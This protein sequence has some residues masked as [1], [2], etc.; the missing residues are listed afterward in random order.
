M[1]R[2]RLYG[3]MILEFIGY[4]VFAGLIIYLISGFSFGEGQEMLLEACALYTMAGGMMIA[5]ILFFNIYQSFV[6][7]ALSL[8][9]RRK[10]VFLGLQIVK[11]LEAFGVTA[12]AALLFFLGITLGKDSGFHGGIWLAVM[13]FCLMFIMASVG[14]L[15]GS[16]YYRFGKIAMA[17]MVIFAMVCGG[18]IGFSSSMGADNELIE[19]LGKLA[20]LETAALF[21]AGAA[22]IVGILDAVLS[23]IS[24]RKMEIRC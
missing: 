7:M 17:L 16:L 13:A 23:W 18:I 4:S 24:L 22:L 10:E 15:A 8:N 6:P 12:V 20:K 9:A 11:L 1:K 19:F 14:N 2:Y 21:M 3:G 5:T